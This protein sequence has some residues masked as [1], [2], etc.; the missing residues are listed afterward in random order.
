VIIGDFNIV[1]V[2]SI[3]AEAD[4]PLLIDADAML[5]EAVAGKR[6]KAI[7]RGDAEF[8]KRS[9]VFD[10]VE[11]VHGAAEDFGGQLHMLPVPEFLCPFVAESFN[12]KDKLRAA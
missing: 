1:S 3:P 2:S 7:G 4:A 11:F 9:G 8:I 6:L 5:P 10:D 12:H